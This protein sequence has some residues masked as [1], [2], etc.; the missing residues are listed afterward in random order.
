MVWV[1]LDDGIAEHPKVVA[2]GDAGLAAF[3]RGLCYCGRNLTD[4]FIPDQIARKLGT[5]GAIE[6]LV[7]Q[8]LW[9][10]DGAGFRVH[11]FLTYNPSRETVLK[12]RMANAERQRKWKEERTRR[13]QGNAAGN[14]V[15]NAANN[16]TVTGAP[17][18]PPPPALLRSA[19]GRGGDGACAPEERRAAPTDSKARISKAMTDAG[20]VGIDE[21]RAR[22]ML[23]AHGLDAVERAN[24]AALRCPIRTD[25]VDAWFDEARAPA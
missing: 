22:D 11:D 19:R 12:D 3:V 8:G 2:T 14:G 24:A 17:P 9:A 10:R 5:K 4:G 18:P 23:D 20:R 15:S 21:A 13:R 16:A 6:A 25:A 7:A 1:R